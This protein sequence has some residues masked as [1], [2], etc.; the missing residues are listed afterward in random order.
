[1]ALGSSDRVIIKRINFVL[2]LFFI[3]V[4]GCLFSSVAGCI[5]SSRRAGVIGAPQFIRIR[6][7]TDDRKKL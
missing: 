4:G 2:N 5:A 3:F 1:M 7:H 6:I